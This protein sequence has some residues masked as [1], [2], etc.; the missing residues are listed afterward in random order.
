MYV[1]RI[2]LTVFQTFLY[3][4]ATVGGVMLICA[5]ALLSLVIVAAVESKD[6]WALTGSTSGLV[7]VVAGVKNARNEEEIQRHARRE[8]R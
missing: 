7:L 3:A 8:R 4:L 1:K 5:A 6:W 2:A